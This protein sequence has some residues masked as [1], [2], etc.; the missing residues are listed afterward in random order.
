MISDI[1]RKSLQIEYYIPEDTIL[2]ADEHLLE[3]VLRNLVMNAV[4]FSHPNGKIEIHFTEDETFQYIKVKDY[5]IG[6]SIR[7]QSNLFEPRRNGFSLGTFGEK[8][9]GLGLSLS[10]EIVQAHFGHI[11]VESEENMGSSFTVALPSNKKTVFLI[12]KDKEKESNFTNKMIEKKLLPI[13]CDSYEK[14]PELLD[15]I[16]PKCIFVQ[17]KQDNL[18]LKTTLQK[19][20]ERPFV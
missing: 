1:D 11:S 17:D 2:T 12:L 20:F 16:S 6:I 9:F 14:I 3:E 18:E 8:G 5:G 13:S 4:K 7:F 10:R 15:R 19:P